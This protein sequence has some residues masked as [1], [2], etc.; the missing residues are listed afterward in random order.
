MFV[1]R[2]NYGFVDIYNIW[3]N[4]RFGFLIRYNN[5]NIEEVFVWDLVDKVLVNDNIF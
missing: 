3:F 4:I 2:R 1:L 5:I